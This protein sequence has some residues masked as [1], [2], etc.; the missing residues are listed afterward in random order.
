[1]THNT[2]T[3]KSVWWFLQTEVTTVI[4]D[5]KQ[6]KK[7][8]DMADKFQTVK[9]VVYME[10]LNDTSDPSLTGNSVNWSV[11]SFSHVES[12]GQQSPVEANM[13][14]PRDVAVI[15]YTSGSTGMPKVA[16]LC[17]V[18]C[19][20]LEI[21]SGFRKVGMRVT[22]VA[23]QFSSYFSRIVQ[24]VLFSFKLCR[25]G[26]YSKAGDT[27]FSVLLSNVPFVLS[28]H[29]GIRRLL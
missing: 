10:D 4:C 8:T 17:N 11:E 5:R 28:V 3:L 22:V 2:C 21:L 23:K 1:M 20:Q 19:L 18:I 27:L 15:M 13:P 24:M 6:L 9:N 16:S 29:V 14:K 26:T 12:L 25:L 7:L